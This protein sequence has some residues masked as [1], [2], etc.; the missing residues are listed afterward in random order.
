L[1]LALPQ[2]LFETRSSWTISSSLSPAVTTTLVAMFLRAFTTSS[3]QM[4]LVWSVWTKRGK[5][6]LVC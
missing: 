6:S 5:K 3:T 1:S 4:L 2:K